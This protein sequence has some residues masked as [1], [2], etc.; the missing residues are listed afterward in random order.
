MEQ[1]DDTVRP[2][3]KVRKILHIPHLH[4]KELKGY[5]TKMM[6]MTV[7]LQT[8]TQKCYLKNQM[9]QEWLLNL[10]DNLQVHKYVKESLGYYWQIKRVA[11]NNIYRTKSYKVDTPKFFCK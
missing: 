1:L 5:Q 3:N 4:V 10:W 8:M 6:K 7:L 9:I 2:L 11:G